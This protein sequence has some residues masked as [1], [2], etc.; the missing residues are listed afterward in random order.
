MTQG[1]TVL[2]DTVLMVA[3]TV[4][5]GCY[6]IARLTFS[7]PPSPSAPR[8]SHQQILRQTT[9]IQLRRRRFYLKYLFFLSPIAA[10][11]DPMEAMSTGGP[12]PKD[13]N[14]DDAENMEDVGF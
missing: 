12:V 7:A 6:I 9:T 4:S 8:H 13:F 3:S 5:I 1:D 2:S 14:A 10:N 11:M